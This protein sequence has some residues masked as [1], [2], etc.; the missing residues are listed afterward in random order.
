MI[1]KFT[2]EEVKELAA[3][4]TNM[5]ATVSAPLGIISERIELE[6]ARH[7]LMEYCRDSDEY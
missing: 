2:I 7:G 6:L 1:K 5:A 4:V 3:V